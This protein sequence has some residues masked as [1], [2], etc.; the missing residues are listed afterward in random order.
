M[1]GVD[2]QVF[3]RDSL[4]AYQIP[5]RFLFVDTLPRTASLKVDRNAVR[6]LFDSRSSD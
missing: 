4:L 1:Q 5:A 3:L 6:S 2:L